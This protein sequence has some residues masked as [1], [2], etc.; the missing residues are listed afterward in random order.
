VPPDSFIDE[1]AASLLKKDPLPRGSPIHVNEVNPDV[2]REL[3]PHYSDWRFL[4]KSN[5]KNLKPNNRLKFFV[6]DGN[7]WRDVSDG[8]QASRSNEWQAFVKPLYV[9]KSSG[10]SGASRSAV[11]SANTMPSYFEP[12]SLIETP[13][14]LDTQTHWVE[15]NIFDEDGQPVEQELD[16]LVR[17]DDGAEIRSKLKEGTDY[18]TGVPFMPFTIDVLPGDEL[19]EKLAVLR[20]KLRAELD[21]SIAQVKADTAI[22]EKDWAKIGNV[23]AGF[24][25]LGSGLTGAGEWIVD[26]V[27]GVT[28]L[29]TGIVNANIT[30]YAWTG[31][32]INHRVNAFSSYAIG[33]VEGLKQSSQ[34]IETMHKELGEDVSEIGEHAETLALL[35]WDDETRNMLVDFPGDYF[36]ELSGV[37]Q[38]RAVTRYGIDFLLIFVGGVGAGVLAIKNSAKISKLLKEM[39]ELIK[40]LRFKQ[41]AKKPKVDDTYSL[42]QPK[43]NTTSHPYQ[44]NS[45]GSINYVDPAVTKKIND[46]ARKPN[47]TSDGKKVIPLGK[48]EAD[49]ITIRNKRNLDEDGYLRKGD[50][51]LKYDDDGF[52]VFNSKFDTV[53]DDSNLGTGKDKMHFKA[54]NENLAKELRKN[55]E[56]AKDLGI[57]DKQVEFILKEPPEKTAPN[58]L[59][60]H[61]HQ[62]TGRMQLVDS[63]EHGDFKHT[64]GMSIWGGGY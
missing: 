48:T 13:E 32:Y 1:F 57:T 43:K 41:T 39:L 42:E 45:D 10:G 29:A 2:L 17:F 52:P 6:K 19:N 40:Q 60:W 12:I 61:H 24:I 22:H 33:D 3:K 34:S 59:T 27:K 47:L 23:E 44:K 9:Q 16:Y 51:K 58:G 15:F 21:T 7:H 50:K 37:E 53:I 31:K 8:Q 49:A 26:T 56:I 38:T 46:P 18:L 5:A 55:P 11:A 54:A 28:E 20:T 64:G 62:D 35:A 36:A 63:V 25:Y 30:T 4:N 14:A